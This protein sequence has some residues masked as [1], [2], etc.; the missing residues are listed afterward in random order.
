MA[1]QGI[2]LETWENMSRARHVLKKYSA[3]GDLIDEMIGSKKRFVVSPVERRINQELAATSDLD[4]FANGQFNPVRLVDGT[5]DAEEIANNPNLMSE[6]EMGELIKGKIDPLRA[7]VGEVRNAVVL[8]R[9]LEVADELD[10]PVSKINAIRDRL[11]EVAP[12]L[13]VQREAL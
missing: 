6:T 3:K 12:P 11:T 1:E 8:R 4:P 9:L 5:E 10:A 2:D 7:R 13:S